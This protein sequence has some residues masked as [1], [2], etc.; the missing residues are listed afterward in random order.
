MESLFFGQIHK[1]SGIPFE[2]AILT[3]FLATVFQFKAS[4]VELYATTIILQLIFRLIPD[5]P[6][7]QISN[8]VLDHDQETAEPQ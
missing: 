2:T 3:V 8:S 1:E 5:L 4:L 7:F 6:K